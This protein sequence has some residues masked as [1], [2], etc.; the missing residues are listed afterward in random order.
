M[1]DATNQCRYEEKKPGKAE[2]RADLVRR[3]FSVA[4]GA[5]LTS[6]LIQ[7]DWLKNGTLPTAHEFEAMSVLGTG[8]VLMILSWEGYLRSIGKR[9]LEQWPRFVLDILL[10][11]LYMIFLVT[12][13][14]RTFFLPI[15]AFVFLLYV[16]WD[17][18]SILEYPEQYDKR[19]REP[20]QKLK[21]TDV[22]ARKIAE[23][24]AQGFLGA[25]YFNRGPII[26]LSWTIYFLSLLWIDSA[27]GT[28]IYLDCLAAVT[29]LVLYR[30][31]KDY[32]KSTSV[33]IAGFSMRCRA[34]VIA[35]LLAIVILL[36]V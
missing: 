26:T 24:Y 4:I 2:N 16:V 29:G 15:L 18:L 13:K 31:D 19:P 34:I 35:G 30:V 23:I 21:P 3:F 12:S 33:D 14:N 6:T 28:A 5:G 7:M 36:A 27:F 32:K 25:D 17:I 8:F 20:E 9:P 11:T 10:V 22:G 1:N